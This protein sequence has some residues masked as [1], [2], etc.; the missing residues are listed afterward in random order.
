MASVNKVIILGRIGKD[1]ELSYTPSGVPVCKFSVAT[2]EKYTDKAGVKQEKTD[3]HNVVLWQKTA[4]LAKQYCHK[5]SLIYIEG[6][7]QT[8]SWD[9]KDG[10]KRYATEIV[11]NSI[12]F[13]DGKK[14]D[15]TVSEPRQSEV[16]EPLPQDDKYLP[17]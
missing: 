11:G 15:D 7:I 14:P 9:D 2:S 12:Q 10:T 17:F 6:K 1:P 5:G 13:L 3:W 16:S 8:R 4:E